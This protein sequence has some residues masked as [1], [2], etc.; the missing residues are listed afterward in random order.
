[1]HSRT[2]SSRHM[3]H[4][5]ERVTYDARVHFQMWPHATQVAPIGQQPVCRLELYGWAPQQTPGVV[6]EKASEQS[7]LKQ[8]LSQPTLARLRPCGGAATSPDA[9][10]PA[11]ARVIAQQ[12]FIA[13]KKT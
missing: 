12:T 2:W 10:A 6:W 5:L 9:A 1:M 11:N 3:P 13:N 4:L 7:F 8:Q